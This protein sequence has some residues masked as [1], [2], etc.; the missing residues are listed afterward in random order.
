MRFDLL[1]DPPGLLGAVPNTD[2]SDLLAVPCVGP[3]G[4]AEATC[5]VC[6]QPIGS[7]EDMRCRAVILLESND[8]GARKVF[9][10]TENVR[11]FGAAPRIDR[12][13]VV[14]DATEVPLRLGEELQPFVLR[15]IGVLI[16]VDQDVAEALAIS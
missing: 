10:E 13:V 15:L 8:L 6:D 4:L 12:L 2:D 16:F 3:Q 1:A 11:D 14:A 7:G 5:I 9:F